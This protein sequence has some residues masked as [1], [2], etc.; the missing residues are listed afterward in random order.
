MLR[1]LSF[2][3]EIFCSEEEVGGVIQRHP[4]LMLDGSGSKAFSLITV[5]VKLG[6]KKRELSSLFLQF[7]CFH[8][9]TFT[10]N[11]RQA[12]LFL[13]EIEMEADDI[14]KIISEHSTLVGSFALKKP[15]SNFTNLNVRKKRL[16][17]IIKE[18]PRQ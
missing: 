12:L 4:G 1:I 17:N 9:G 16:C 14:M 18:D 3:D 10:R 2:F 13:V 8:V 15:I 7:P 11:F 5:L 6:F